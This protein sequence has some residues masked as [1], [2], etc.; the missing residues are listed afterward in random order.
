M[1]FRSR[2]DLDVFHLYSPE[3]PTC[4]TLRHNNQP[5]QH[6][7]IPTPRTL[8]SSDPAKL[9]HSDPSLTFRQRKAKAQWRNL[10]SPG[11][12]QLFPQDSTCLWALKFAAL[13]ALNTKQGIVAVA[14]LHRM[15]V[16]RQSNWIRACD[17]H[18]SELQAQLIAAKFGTTG[19]SWS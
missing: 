1:L 16:G 17:G 14:T 5:D 2:N 7:I 19:Q 18:I 10:L 4:S 6:S 12:P 9:C 3:I 11:P 15:D 8:C 13:K